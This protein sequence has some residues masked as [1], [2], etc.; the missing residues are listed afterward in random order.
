MYDTLGQAG[1]TV[2]SL[3][4]ATEIGMGVNAMEL[5]DK[6]VLDKFPQAVQLARCL[7]AFFRPVEGEEAES[8][9]ELLVYDKGKYYSPCVYNG[10][11]RGHKVYATGDRIKIVAPTRL[12]SDIHGTEDLPKGTEV[13]MLILGRL[14]DQVN[15][16][17]GEKTNPGPIVD[18][19]RGSP[20]VADAVVFGSDRMHNGLLI[21]L[22]PNY[23]VPHDDES[24]ARGRN[25]V[26]PAVQKANS[27]APSHSYMYVSSTHHIVLYSVHYLHDGRLLTKLLSASDTER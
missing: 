7:N 20:I 15:L 3:Y 22:A 23:P 24:L 6:S 12:G 2:N 27:A 8:H 13:Y 1:V 5:Y 18:T 11:Y 9:Y 26:W 10:I 25:Q 17:T 21:E 19:V 16:A 14:D 4:G